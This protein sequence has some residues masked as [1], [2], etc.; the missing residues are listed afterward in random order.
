MRKLVVAAL[1]GCLAGIQPASAMPGAEHQALAGP[2]GSVYGYITR[3]ITISKGDSITFTNLDVTRHDFVQDV[4]TD[5]K[6]GRKNAPWCKEE[7]GHAHH[8]HG[9]PVFWS[10]LVD[11]QGS[12]KVKGLRRVKPGTTYTF[13]CTI[14]HE[15][16]GTLTVEP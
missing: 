6:G 13:F 15:M 12:T 9:C 16:K 11:F 10:K 2:G 14:H 5:G 3:D 4:E 1:I 7:K 8:D